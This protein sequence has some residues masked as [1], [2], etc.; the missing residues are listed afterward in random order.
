MGSVKRKGVTKKIDARKLTECEYLHLTMGLCIDHGPDC[1]KSKGEK[2]E[3]WLKHKDTVMERYFADHGPGFRP[4][5][6]WL[7]EYEPK[8][9]LRQPNERGTTE[10]DIVY[11]VK[12]DL[13]ED[14]EKEEIP[15]C[16]NSWMKRAMGIPEN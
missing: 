8:F 3:L 5:S 9:G 7:F 10:Q 2:R 6:W 13:L 12:H 16:A 11:L 14:W 4:D 15:R 1:H